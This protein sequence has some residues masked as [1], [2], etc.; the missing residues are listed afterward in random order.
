MTYSFNGGA[1]SGTTVY[2]SLAAGTYNVVVKDANGCTFPTTA[3]V[4]NTPGPT[5]VVLTPTNASCGTANGSFTIGAVTGG[6]AAYTYSV[7][8]G[9]FTATTSYPG[10]AAGTYTITVKDANGCQYTQNVVINNSSGPTALAVT[11]VNTNCGA[12]NG[13]LTIGA[14][15][16]G[17]AAYTYSVN[18]SAFT[19]TTSYPGLA[20]GTYTVVVKD[21][22]GCTFTVN[23]VI[24]N[25]P[26]PTAVVLTPT[27]STCGAANGSFTIGAVTGGTSAYTYSINGGAFTATTNYPGQAA[28]TYTVNGQPDSQW[29]RIWW[30]K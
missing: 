10:Q 26:G 7:N 28:A 9:A 30:D 23:P 15:T 22:N 29:G 11:P 6:T 18:G 2:N 20:A 13:S 5:A 14:V 25:N 8:G 17:V 1:F 4:V 27:N 3:T 24:G 21:A 19:A 12:A 16:G